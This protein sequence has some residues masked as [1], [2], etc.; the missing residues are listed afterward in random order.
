M[1]PGNM[2]V[3]T[4]NK[5]RGMA[6]VARASITEEF[7]LARLVIRFSYVLLKEEKLVICFEIKPTI[8][9]EYQNFNNT[10]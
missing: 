10:S 4:T 5:K 8:T 6:D 1:V 3:A 9:K 7:C 2:D